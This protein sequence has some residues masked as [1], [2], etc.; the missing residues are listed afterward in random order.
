M[1]GLLDKDFFFHCLEDTQRAKGR[2]GESQEN[3]V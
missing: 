2:G 1:A 3:E